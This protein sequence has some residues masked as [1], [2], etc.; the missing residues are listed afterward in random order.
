MRSLV[1]LVALLA[2]LAFTPA[3]AAQAEIGSP[4]IARALDDA[5]SGVVYV[6]RGTT[7]PLAGPNTIDRWSF[8]DDNNANGKVTPLIFEKTGANA[9]VVV[10]IGT[11][12]TS[13]GAGVQSHAFDTI[14]GTSVLQAGK[15]YTIGFTHRAYSGSGANV[16]A[17]APNA[18]VV[19]FDGYN[20]FTDTWSYAT[21]I[22]QIGAL[23]G[24]GGFALDGAGFAGRIY[25][26]KCATTGIGSVTGCQNNPADLA[27]DVLTLSPGTAFE[28]R[29]SSP[30]FAEGFQ[31]VWYGVPSVTPLGCGIL[32]P[33][34]GEAFI[35]PGTQVLAN[36]GF[37]SGGAG[38]TDLSVPP[39]SGLVG[40]QV[41]MQGV[42]VGVFTTG[43][44]IELTNGL[45]ATI[46]P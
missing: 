13:T 10:A 31:Q 41:L 46:V 8:F 36:S 7:Q 9:W 15:S 12:R 2:N 42:A 3:A 37:Y 38:Y 22:A 33:G 39:I 14:A 32:L 29:V 19:D 1:L 35:L 43:A 34:L 5:S 6:Y 18:G 20:I 24:T 45:L 11:T 23:Y 30:N 25:S 28:L 17:G 40:A 16:V 26:M 21:G 4:T 27:I 44:P